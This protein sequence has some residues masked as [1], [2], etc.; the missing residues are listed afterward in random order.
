MTN[1]ELSG[2]LNL[3]YYYRILGKCPHDCMRCVI[4]GE[5]LK[6]GENRLNLDIP[7][8]LNDPA[9]MWKIMIGLL[10][11]GWEYYYIDGRDVFVLSYTSNKKV[12]HQNPERAVMLALKAKM[13]R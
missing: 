12:E 8:H 5:C 13:E 2:W 11:A 1:D 3:W 10:R 6:C 7:D 4:T 9:V